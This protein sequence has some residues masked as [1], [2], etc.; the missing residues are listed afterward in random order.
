MSHYHKIS[1]NFFSTFSPLRHFK[2]ID[3][4]IKDILTKTLYY[5]CATVAIDCR[6]LALAEGEGFRHF[7]IIPSFTSPT[8]M[9]LEIQLRIYLQT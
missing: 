6:P 8:T 1:T 9:L 2:P 5:Y 4:L 3:R 7:F